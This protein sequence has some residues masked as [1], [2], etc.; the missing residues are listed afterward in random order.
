MRLIL[1]IVL[2]ITGAVYAISIKA[3]QGYTEGSQ[4]KLI[5]YANITASLID[6]DV[7]DQI[8]PGDEN[9]TGFLQIRDQLHRVEHHSEGIRDIYALRKSGETIAYI[10]DV[11]YGYD[12][13]APGI[14][15]PYNPVESDISLNF[16]PTPYRVFSSH[17][18]ALLSGFSPIQNH[19]GEIVGIVG[20]D[21][22]SAGITGKVGY[23][24]SILFGIGL[25]AIIAAIII[26]VLIDRQREY[27]NA[28]LRE[29]EER[30]RHLFE[31]SGDAIF[32][33]EAEGPRTGMITTANTAATRIHGYSAEEFYSMSIADLELEPERQVREA[34]ISTVMTGVWV[35]RELMHRRKDGSVFPV[36]VYAGL[37]N[38]GSEKM[39]L[40]RVRDISERIQVRKALE[41]SSKKLNLLNAVTFSD[42]QNLMY[43]LQGY[44]DLQQSISDD[45]EVLEF[46]KKEDELAR[47]ISRSLEFARE[48]QDLGTRPPRWQ[49]VQGAFILGISHLDF[50]SIHRT[51]NLDNLEIFVDSSLERVFFSLASNVVIHGKTASH[52]LLEYHETPEELVIIFEDNGVGIPDALKEQI[53]ERGFG[54]HKGMGLFLVREILGITDITII[55][56]GTEGYGARFEIHVPHGGYRFSS[57]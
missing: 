31:H 48:Y 25:L 50:T 43:G 34:L 52:L 39:I 28:R 11:N 26:I 14:G 19:N 8:Q 53:F 7:L 22:D 5:S 23:I 29:S 18:G 35:Y 36:E 17:N 45:Q 21:L 47:K 37:I 56:T 16:S 46:L 54:T 27:D 12:P 2:I 33:I 15:H 9:S 10:V 55:E 1:L 3:E 13:E 40:V 24:K 32:L 6:G 38:P 42:I 57:G 4:G 41:Q 44:I 49:Q 20:V 30:Y 51:V